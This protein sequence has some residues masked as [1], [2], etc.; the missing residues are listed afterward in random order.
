MKRPYIICHILSA[1]DGKI[2]GLFM[3]TKTAKAVSEEYA[4]I[5]S[6]YQ[7]AD[8]VAMLPLELTLIE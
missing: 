3:R 4:R 7:A 1:L 8:L 2:T 6:E 5:R